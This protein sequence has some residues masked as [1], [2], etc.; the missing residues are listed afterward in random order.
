MWWVFSSMSVLGFLLLPGVELCE[1]VT[2]Q[3]FSSVYVCLSSGH[4]MSPKAVKLS[5]AEAFFFFSFTNTQWRFPQ[6]SLHPLSLLVQ[7]IPPSCPVSHFVPKLGSRNPTH[8]ADVC[9]LEAYRMI[10]RMLSYHAGL[11]LCIRS[12]PVNTLRSE[13]LTQCLQIFWLSV[14]LRSHSGH[15]HVVRSG[16]AVIAAPHCLFSKPQNNYTLTQTFWSR[17]PPSKCSRNTCSV[18]Y[19]WDLRRYKIRLL[20]ADESAAGCVCQ[21]HSASGGKT[22]GNRMIRIN[23]AKKRKKSG[24][25]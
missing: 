8:A 11:R 17:S 24:A 2:Q 10:S 23:N 20:C 5:R 25:K 13:L 19:N 22:A 14:C 7:H 16:C 18:Y 3:F 1:M 4:I 9:T 21:T 15:V 6:S 12:E